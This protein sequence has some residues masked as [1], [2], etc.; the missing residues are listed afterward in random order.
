MTFGMS[1]MPWLLSKSSVVMSDRRIIRHTIDEVGRKLSLVALGRGGSKG[2]ATI[3]E[4]DLALLQ[5]LGLSLSWNRMHSTGVVIAPAK[6]ASNSFVQV[7]RVLLDLGPG[8]NVVY[9][10]RDPTN[11][12]RSNLDVNTNGWAIRRDRDFLSPDTTKWGK[13][14]HVWTYDNQ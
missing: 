11:L 9:L 12:L 4:E 1:T 7:A 5:E 2:I 6:K 14:E 3:A 10:D 13:V 8:E